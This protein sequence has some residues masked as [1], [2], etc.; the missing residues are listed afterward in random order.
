MNVLTKEETITADNKE[1]VKVE[2]E[3]TTFRFI[4]LGRQMEAFFLQRRFLLSALKP[5]M[6]VKEDTNELKSELARKEELL[7]RHHDKVA[8]WQNLL[9]DMQVYAKSPVQSTS[10]SGGALSNNNSGGMVQSPVGAV[11]GGVQTT[12]SM[13]LPGMSSVQQQMQQMQ[14][15]QQ[16]QQMQQMQVDRR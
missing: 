12:N 13:G 8:I 11:G 4:D 3:Q 6:I 2:M 9:A 10:G 7:K 1:D 16:I 15:M 5:E 14:Q